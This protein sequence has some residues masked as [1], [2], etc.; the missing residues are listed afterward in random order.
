MECSGFGAVLI[1]GVIDFYTT[2]LRKSIHSPQLYC[3]I[4]LDYVK[5]EHGIYRIMKR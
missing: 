3:H 4:L 5:G 2:L 1:A